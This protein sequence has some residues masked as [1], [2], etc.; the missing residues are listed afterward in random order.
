M[1]R[2]SCNGREWPVALPQTCCLVDLSKLLG[3]NRTESVKR[4]KHKSPKKNL[5]LTFVRIKTTGS[6]QP[7]LSS[8]LACSAVLGPKS[9]KIVE[10]S[11]SHHHHHHHLLLLLLLVVVVVVAASSSFRPPLP[12]SLYLRSTLVTCSFASKNQKAKI[13]K[14]HDLRF[15]N[16]ISSSYAWMM[17]TTYEAT[18]KSKPFCFS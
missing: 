7:E 11:S 5:R 16:F 15:I 8:A 9:S 10:T 1:F 4:Q 3:N 18:A 17:R 12:S 13:H 14:I 6:S 2:I